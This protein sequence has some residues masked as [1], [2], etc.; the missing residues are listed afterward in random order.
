[1]SQS[2]YAGKVERIEKSWGG[3][4][5]LVHVQGRDKPLAY[6]PENTLPDFPQVGDEISVEAREGDYWFFCEH[7]SIVRQNPIPYFDLDEY[8]SSARTA[9]VVRL[10]GKY[11]QNHNQ[12]CGDDIY[13]EA[14]SQ[15]PAK[16][17]PRFIGH[18]FRW[19]YHKG[20]IHKVGTKKSVRVSKSHGSDMFVWERT[21]QKG[22]IDGPT[23]EEIPAQ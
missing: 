22:D 17:D 20:I 7:R 15:V 11:L 18:G 13:E 5:T 4:W 9:L 6:K 12:V 19:L 8:P 14:L 2:L 1:M 3:K 23:P 21:K 10:I 16:T